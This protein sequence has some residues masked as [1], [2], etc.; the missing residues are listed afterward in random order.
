M[1]TPRLRS[2]GR[3]LQNASVRPTTEIIIAIT[4]NMTSSSE[5]AD[6]ATDATAVKAEYS[7]ASHPVAEAIEAFIHRVRDIKLAV[8]LA[9]PAAVKSQTDSLDDIK[10]RLTNAG[11]L[12]KS[13]DESQR[14]IGARE[15][16]DVG[17]RLERLTNSNLPEVIETGLFLSL[18]SAFDAYTGRLLSALYERRPKLFTSLDRTLTL[19]EVLAAP[20]LDELKR[21]VI[22]EDIEQLRR[23]SYVEQFA[24]LSRKFDVPLTKFPNWPTF[25]EASQRRNLQTHCD[26][27]VNEQYLSVC[28]EVGVP[29]AELPRIGTR[30]TLGARYLLST[31]ELL[32]EVGFKLGQVLWRKTLPDEIELAD[33]HL[34]SALYNALLV[35]VWDRARMMGEFAL[36]LPNVHDDLS[37]RMLRVNYAQALRF[38]G[39]PDE[40]RAILHGVDWSASANDFRLAV[41]VLLGEFQE[42][43]NIMK[44]IGRNGEWVDESAYHS[45]PLFTEFR[46]TPEFA[47]AYREVFHRPFAHSVEKEVAEATAKAA[48]VGITTS[49]QHGAEGEVATYEETDASATSI[50][51]ES[52]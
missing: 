21:S 32:L 41:A 37:K 14:V 45:W 1:R 11:L 28:K 7:E 25:V 16:R 39:K 47:T 15:V 18:F 23:K 46:E 20:S 30:L 35:R 27:V 22:A 38:G 5:A 43:S 19:A 49:L 50:E 33:E 4:T 26:G 2:C 34:K 44:R 8:R 51:A 3:L 10:A 36:S 24:T 52:A 12:V 42:A 31:C 29:K 6:P 48:S 17:R 40:A 9:I 13:D